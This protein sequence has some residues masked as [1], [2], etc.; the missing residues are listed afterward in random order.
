[1]TQP[2]RR[3]GRR[4]HGWLPDVLRQAKVQLDALDESTLGHDM[5]IEDCIRT[6]DIRKMFKNDWLLDVQGRQV[7]QVNG[8]LELIGT[9]FVADEDTIFGA[10]DL[11]YIQ[12]E[13]TWYLSGSRSVYD[14]PG[15]PPKIWC[16]VADHDGF[17]NSNYGWMMFSPENGDQARYVIEQLNAQPIGRRAVAIYTRPHMHTDWSV[18]GRSDFVC[19]NAVN[20]YLRDGKLHAVVQMRSNDAIFGYRNDLHWQRWMLGYI[21]MRLNE[22]AEPGHIIWQAGS[23]HVYRRH[24][25]LIEHFAKTGEFDV[26]LKSIK[27]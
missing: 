25:H 21:A 16:D 3:H 24:F 9:S 23:L 10:V 4:D 6:A 19:T 12:R 15:G 26:P 11:G 14:I 1:M 5:I 13:L 27:L 20:Y 17:I 22:D 8:T 2:S 7:R 18:N